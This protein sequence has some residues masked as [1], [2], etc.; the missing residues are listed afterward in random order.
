MRLFSTTTGIIVA[1][2]ISGVFWWY[3]H[4]GELTPTFE[5]NP[6]IRAGSAKGTRTFWGGGMRGGK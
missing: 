4:T 1:T 3:A 2:L 5:N 6:N